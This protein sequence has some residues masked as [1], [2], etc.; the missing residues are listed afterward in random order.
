VP[1]THPESGDL[2]LIIWDISHTVG[3][4]CATSK[5]HEQQ[6]DPHDDFRSVHQ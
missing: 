3:A 1:E 2:T 6:Q 4:W 5:Y